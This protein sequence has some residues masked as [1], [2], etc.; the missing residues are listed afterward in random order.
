MNKIK[1]IQQGLSALELN[2]PVIEDYGDKEQ[3]NRQ[4]TAIASLYDALRQT[5]TSEAKSSRSGLKQQPLTKGQREAIK[6]EQKWPPMCDSYLY[7][8]F[9][10]IDAAEAAHGIK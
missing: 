3:L 10:G 4:H 5:S 7:W 8:F 1:A 2:L 9:K 6:N